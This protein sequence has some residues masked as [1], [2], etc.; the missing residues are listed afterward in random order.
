M[1]TILDECEQLSLHNVAS[2]E[3]AA[4]RTEHLF[5]ENL[6]LLEQNNFSA[7]SMAVTGIKGD[8]CLNKSQYFHIS[9]CKIFYPFHNLL[10]GMLLSHASTIGA[11]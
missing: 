5:A 9:R 3:V 2:T 10:Q 8:C 11:V 4:E 7:E 1:A 6:L